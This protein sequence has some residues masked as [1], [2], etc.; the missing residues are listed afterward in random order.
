[1]RMKGPKH[2]LNAGQGDVEAAASSSINNQKP[3]D[4]LS[5]MADG[6]SC[7]IYRGVREASDMLDQ[8]NSPRMDRGEDGGPFSA[9]RVAKGDLPKADFVLHTNAH[10]PGA[11]RRAI[12][13]WASLVNGQEDDGAAS[14]L[15]RQAA[16]SEPRD[17]VALEAREVALI[18]AGLPHGQLG[19]LNVAVRDQESRVTGYGAHNRIVVSME[20]DG[21]KVH[22]R[23]DFLWGL[24]TATPEQR[25]AVLTGW[26]RIHPKATE[27]VYEA[28]SAPYTGGGGHVSQDHLYLA[29]RRSPEVALCEAHGIALAHAPGNFQAWDWTDSSGACAHRT[30]RTREAAA[31]DAVRV[32]ALGR[33]APSE[34]WIYP[35]AEVLWNDPDEDA[36]CSCHGTVTEVHA[37]GEITGDTIVI[38]RR[39]D[40]TDLECFARELS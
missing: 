40:G 39:K 21:S 30:F 13:S 10:D 9:E 14:S 8:D 17:L 22:A 27:L 25:L 16:T 31:R 3:F 6:R 33:P 20:A 15:R 38:L 35:G 36:D 5:L 18:N 2:E 26:D 11:N 34:T 1:M 19:H 37:E 4:V 29:L 7:R 28:S 23:E 24:P 32:L 12:D